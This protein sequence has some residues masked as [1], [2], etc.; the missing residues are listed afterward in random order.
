MDKRCNEKPQ[1]QTQE[2]LEGINLWRHIYLG[3]EKRWKWFEQ[4]WLG[5]AKK[6]EIRFHIQLIK[7]AVTMT[8]LLRAFNET[9][10]MD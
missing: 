1:T 2:Y 9:R 7:M 8:V 6:I 4:K 10:M 5:S 3:P